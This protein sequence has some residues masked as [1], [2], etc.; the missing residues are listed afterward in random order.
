MSDIEV[1]IDIPWDLNFLNGDINL[2]VPWYLMTSYL[3]YIE[4]VALLHDHQYDLLCEFMHKNW[5]HIKHRHKNC[6]LQASLVAGTGFYLKK[7]DYPMIV[8][9]A[10]QQLAYERGLF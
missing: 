2:T 3:Y 10:A 7:E 8:V 9:N 5:K 4:D 6:I 1:P